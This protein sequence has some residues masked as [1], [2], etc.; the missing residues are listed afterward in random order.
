MLISFSVSN[1]RSIKNK[2]TLSLLPV[3]A[4]KELPDNVFKANDKIN[5]LRS[6]VI[7]G[8]N[9]SGKSNLLR[10]FEQF[11]NFIL[12]STDMKI[13]QK[14]SLFEPFLLDTQSNHKSVRFE[15]EFLNDEQIRYIYSVELKSLQIFKEELY[16]YPKGQKTKIFIR[17]KSKPIDYGTLIKGEKKS[18][19]ARLL[20]NQLFLSKG[21]N[22][23]IMILQKV[24]KYFENNY[25]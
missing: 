10:A 6:A 20:N 18:I 22:E 3:K 1:Y 17:T 21:A 25:F 4:F 12:S 24:Y 14:I 8:A 15:V 23:N 5:L 11:V 2:A 9:A 7:Y 19:E 13:E 16:S